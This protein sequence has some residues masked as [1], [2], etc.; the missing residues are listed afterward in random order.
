VTDKDPYQILG[1]TTNATEAEIKKTYFDLIRVWFEK[2]GS[3]EEFNRLSEAYIT[4][5]T[6]KSSLMIPNLGSEPRMLVK[7]P[8][9]ESLWQ[10][11]VSPALVLSIMF[12]GIAGGLIG[13]SLKPKE[14]LVREIVRESQ[15]SNASP[16]PVPSE[17]REGPKEQ[18]SSDQA[19]IDKAPSK[20][21]G[22]TNP[23]PTSKNATTPINPNAANPA[24]A[25]SISNLAG[26]PKPFRI[27]PVPPP[28]LPVIEQR[29]VGLPQG[30][31]LLAPAQQSPN[32]LPLRPASTGGFPSGKFPGQPPAQKSVPNISNPAEAPAKD[33]EADKLIDKIDSYKTSQQSPQAQGVEP[34]KQSTVATV[35]NAD[36]AESSP[37]KILEAI[38]IPMESG[39]SVTA[40]KLLHLDTS[41]WKLDRGATRKKLNILVSELIASKNLNSACD[42]SGISL[43]GLRLLI[44][45]YGTA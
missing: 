33:D 36:T 19:K 1:L 12:T 18:L 32:L 34:R 11:S 5:S 44:K 20:I 39:I 42:K 24:D 15:V 2:R 13:Y 22:A 7:N 45:K 23:A 38:Q 31:G 35:S 17:D 14:T 37:E 29:P 30:K 3:L 6:L 27:L 40:N 43:E 10:K 9:W 16:A 25:K 4:L 28:A 21:T 26:A 41:M 8:G